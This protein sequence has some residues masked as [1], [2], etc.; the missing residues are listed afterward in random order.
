VSMITDTP[1][2]HDELEQESE[3]AVPDPVVEYRFVRLSKLG[4]GESDA[5]ML[6]GRRTDVYQD[7]LQPG[8]CLHDVER[9][10][11]AGCPL[12]LVIAIRS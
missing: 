6:A 11:A 10:I 8:V 9:L 3:V 12:D 7:E 4:F 5:R 2:E 1:P